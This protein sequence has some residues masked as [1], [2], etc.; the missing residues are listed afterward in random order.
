MGINNMD[1]LVVPL[2][3]PQ[4]PVTTPQG[5]TILFNHHMVLPCGV[6]TGFG[7]KYGYFPVRTQQGGPYD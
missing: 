7:M 5:R 2:R 6:N 3:I 4:N 1:R